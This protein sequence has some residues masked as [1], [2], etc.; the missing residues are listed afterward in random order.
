MPG[1]RTPR[2]PR[3]SVRWDADWGALDPPLFGGA[4]RFERG[5]IIDARFDLDNGQGRATRGDQIYLTRFHTIASLQHAPAKG[6]QPER[7]K[8][9]G[10]HAPALGLH[11]FSF[12]HP[13][14]GKI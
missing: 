8:R 7:G 6:L 12:L 10:A 3:H 14:L 2:R 4:D 5:P 1:V 13:G 9:L 11:A